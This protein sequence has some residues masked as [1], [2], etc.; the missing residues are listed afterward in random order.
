[1][2]GAPSEPPLVEDVAGD[3]G[4][5]I[6]TLFARTA[7]ACSLPPVAVRE[8]VENLVHADFHGACVS[9]LD[10]GSTVRVSDQGPGIDDKDRALEPGFSTADGRVREVVRGVGSGFPVAAA[11]MQAVGGEL[12]V[13]DNL[14]GG[15][16]VT[17]TAPHGAT[18]APASSPQ[19][20]EVARRALAVLVEV[21]SST[22]EAIAAEL[23]FPLPICGREL[24]LLESRGLV[25][26][27]G[28]GSYRLTDD[29]ERLV[30][31]L[32]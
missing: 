27:A 9:V 13:D 31:T 28:D 14:R 23:D 30:S 29:G 6:E 5:V 32:F 19:L 11:A 22:P 21:G 20:T 25:A 12:A 17:L 7:G 24:V 15:T 3:P 2:Y 8:I 16:V 10:G 1:M 18:P 26:R 4:V